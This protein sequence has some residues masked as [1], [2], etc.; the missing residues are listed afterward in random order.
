MGCG[1]HRGGGCGRGSKNPKYLQGP[2]PGLLPSLM[3]KVPC[4]RVSACPSSLLA[5]LCPLSASFCP[6]SFLF[7]HLLPFPSMN[8]SQM[9]R[10]GRS[11]QKA[12]RSS[13]SVGE[14]DTQAGCHLVKWHRCQGARES[15]AME[16]RRRWDKGSWRRNGH[17]PLGPVGTRVPEPIQVG[18]VADL[19]RGDLVSGV[20][21]VFLRTLSTQD[22][23]MGPSLEISPLHMEVGKDLR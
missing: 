8:I 23:V 18:R 22:L 4:L 15:R 3:P 12:S 13:E 10:L 2:R 14:G 17:S 11:G 5:L 21:R 7:L 20:N 9:P 19:R 6:P 1:D 16:P